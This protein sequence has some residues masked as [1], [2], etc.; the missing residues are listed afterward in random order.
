M[1]GS[2]GAWMICGVR[3][4]LGRSKKGAAVRKNGPFA[5]AFGMDRM[6]AVCSGEVAGRS[7]CH[8]ELVTTECPRVPL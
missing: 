4:Q 3:E 7:I 1:A 8:A 5:R 2:D 6:S